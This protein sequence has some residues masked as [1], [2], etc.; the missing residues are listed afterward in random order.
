MQ[1]DCHPA[2]VI[3]QAIA[4]RRGYPFACHSVRSRGIQSNIHLDS[5]T[6]FHSA[7]NDER[8]AA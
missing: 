4:G 1:Y 6:T 8:G 7:Q 5:A 3:L 2:R